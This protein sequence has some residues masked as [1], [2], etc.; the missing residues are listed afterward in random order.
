MVLGGTSTINN[1][2]YTQGQIYD[3]DDWATLG[4]KGWSWNDLLPYFRKS[5]EVIT[6]AHSMDGGFHGCSP[7]HTSSTPQLYE[8]EETWMEACRTALGAISP[9]AH[10]NT[11]QG[12]ESARTLS[13]IDNSSSK[14]VQNNSAS[15]CLATA[16]N[17]DNLDILVNSRVSRVIFA[18]Q[19]G[20][21]TAT[22][23]EFLNDD[24]FYTISVFREVIIC[25]GAITT[26]L[27][28]ERSGIGDPSILSTARVRTLLANSQV[29]TNLQDHI[30]SGVTYSLPSETKTMDHLHDYN[31]VVKSIAEYETDRTRPLNASTVAE[32]FIT[33][34]DIAPA[35]EIEA[36]AALCIRPNAL[37]TS[38]GSQA[39]P[40]R[41]P[42][43]IGL[44]LLGF[45]RHF[46]HGKNAY[47]RRSFDQYLEGK[48][49]FTMCV[50]LQHPFSRGSS[51]IRDF[52][53]LEYPAVDFGHLSHP[54]DVAILSSALRYAERCFQVPCLK[55]KCIERVHPRPEIDM[56]DDAQLI[57]VIRGCSSAHH[58][59]GTAAMGKVVDERL[60]V[61]GTKGL[62]VCDASIF[63]ASVGGNIVATIYAIAEKAADMIKQDWS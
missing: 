26:P 46:D 7:T 2:R 14:G 12:K 13:T 25:A 33:Y 21:Y 17:R 49:C 30:V 63:P 24:S 9:S 47:Q 48:G 58:F 62:R 50:C 57:H 56:Q 6:P 44:Q 20:T 27:I 59:L 31:V 54:A 55:T 23:V 8:I 43:S 60:R 51:H 40:T 15:R 28:L 18:N 53:P 10:L 32:S 1:M 45:P 41:S 5:E 42:A 34:G 3:Y 37:S 35:T 39:Q 22:G 38:E 36:T 52:N 29:G 61:K 16:L 19:P 11:E 4:C